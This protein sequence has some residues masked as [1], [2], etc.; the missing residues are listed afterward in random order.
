MVIKEAYEKFIYDKRLAGL[1]EK[2][3]LSYQYQLIGFFRYIGHDMEVSSI[4]KRDVDDYIMSLYD[5]EV[6]KGTRHSYIR[7]VR[8][9]LCWAHKIEPLSFEPKEIKVP[10]TPKKQLRVYSD[11]EVALIF[12]SIKNDI[13]WLEIRDKLIVALMYD[14]GLRQMEV[15]NLRWKDVQFAE[16]RMIVYGKGDKERYVPLGETCIDMMDIFHELCPYK[17]RLLVFCSDVGENLSTNAIKL[18]FQRLKKHLP[19]EISSHKLR[20]NFATNYCID[21]MEQF[22]HVDSLSLKTVMGHSSLQTT[23][24]YLHYASSIMAVKSSR[25]H[26]DGIKLS[27]IK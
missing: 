14:S 23:E 15:C 11:E 6:S 3:I 27:K 5:S 25:S 4:S 20:H 16:K 10:K 2:S 17:N 19:F 9:F 13:P 26:L 18:M 22:G 12:S 1:S 24:K 8:I 21:Q 7:S